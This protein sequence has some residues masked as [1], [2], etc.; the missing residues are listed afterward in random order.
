MTGQPVGEDVPGWSVRAVPDLRPLPGRTCSLRALSPHDSEALWTAYEPTSAEHWTYLPVDRPSGVEAVRALLPRADGGYLTYAILVEGRV[1]GML[2]LMR[3]DPANGVIE[4]GWICL[5]A[6]LQRTTAATEAQRLVMGHIFDD[7]GYRRLEWK[8]DALN[9]PSRRAAERLG[10]R[11]EGI[12]R[13]HVV[14]KGRNRDTA[15][16]AVVDGEWP[17]VR[18][19]LDH[20]LDPSNFDAQGRALSSLRAG[21]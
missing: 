17:R 3:P 8:C 16:Y 7:L 14:T 18:V 15:W 1:E 2:S 19:A 5:G 10:Y 21:D 4:V 11:F 6:R 12:F 9:A 13:Q 20:W